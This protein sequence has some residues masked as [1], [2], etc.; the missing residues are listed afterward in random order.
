MEE[1]LLAYIYS[2]FVFPLLLLSLVIM[3][4]DR[5]NFSSGI[6]VDLLEA[7]KLGGCTILIFVSAQTDALAA[8]AIFKVKMS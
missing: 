7:A 6:Y 8:A 1:R 3:L 2:N 5:I 4:L